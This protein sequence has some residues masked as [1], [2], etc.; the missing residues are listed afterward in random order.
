MPAAAAAACS[1][2]DARPLCHA[3]VVMQPHQLCLF[4]PIRPLPRIAPQWGKLTCS[5]SQSIHADD[6][7]R[8][9]D[10]NVVNTLSHLQFSVSALS[11]TAWCGSF[12]SSRIPKC[13][14]LRHGSRK[15]LVSALN[16]V[17]KAIAARSADLCVMWVSH[18]R[19]YISWYRC[20][21][22]V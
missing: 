17:C 2:A 1:L 22:D 18:V 21:K 14:I 6:L 8:L 4:I 20:R 5:A 3:A 19:C 15:M 7:R 16:N 9:L 10:A 13:Q 11:K 12:G